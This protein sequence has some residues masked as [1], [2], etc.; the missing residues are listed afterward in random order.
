MSKYSTHTSQGTGQDADQVV[1]LRSTT[2][3]RWT[4][5]VLWAF[6]RAKLTA[7]PVTIA[8][9]GTGAASAAAARTAL[10]VDAAGDSRPPSG[11]AGG[12]LSGTYPNP[13]FAVDMATQGELNSEATTRADADTTLGTAL[14]A[15]IARAQDAEAA[16]QAYSIQ[17]ENHT[18]TQLA[19]TISDFFS[20]VRSTVLTGLSLAYADAIDATDTVLS[21]LGK[22]QGQV[23]LKAPINDTDLTGSTTIET[24]F[25]DG[26]NVETALAGK[27]ALNGDSDES[28]STNDL[29]A[30]GHVAAEGGFS[31]SGAGISNLNA[32]AL[33]SGTVPVARLPAAT[34]SAAGAVELATSA[35]A[36][37]GLDTVRA[38]TPAALA[39]KVDPLVNA[40]QPR[41][42]LVFDGTNYS[43]LS[44]PPFGTQDFSFFLWVTI[45]DAGVDQGFVG[46]DSNAFGL[47][48]IAGPKFLATKVN[49]ADASAACAQSLQLGRRYLVGYTRTGTAGTYWLDGVAAGTCVDSNDYSAPTKYLGGLTGG[50]FMRG[51]LSCPLFYNYAL[52]DAQVADLFMAGAPAAVDR[53]GSMTNIYSGQNADFN[54]G[55]GDWTTYGASTPSAVGNKMRVTINSGISGAAIYQLVPG[56]ALGRK[57]LATFT[58]SNFN[59]TS[60]NAGFTIEGN[61]GV[62][63]TGNGVKSGV[64]EVTSISSGGI[65]VFIGGSGTGETFDVDD[66]SLI[67]LGTLAQYDAHQI[68]A[69][70]QWRDVN[71]TTPPAHINLPGDGVT[72]GVAWALSASQ[73]T[74]FGETRTASGYALGRDAVVIPE[75]YRIESIWWSGDGTASFGN[76]AS[77]TEVINAG[78]A[79][80]T[81]LPATIAAYE[82][83]SRKLYITLG[84]ATTITYTVR[85]VR[86]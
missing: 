82:T 83:A 42:A 29:D 59:L 65:P 34:T 33:S 70:P 16:V 24:L 44:G 52:T 56:L 64:I 7:T 25:L 31:G 51:A 21:A 77:G 80:A 81:T 61:I 26:V 13:G 38:V 6:F 53:G 17:R 47:R 84:T 68:G 85:L 12:V 5:A 18:G 15:E 48:F 36:I 32:D 4:L 69:G 3:S 78:T 50:V 54:G 30:G 27:A 37:T 58:V 75:G 40:R 63:I 14:A 46:G 57:Y 1:G 22:L 86:I 66:F 43:T 45:A 60:G 41:Q 62:A 28:F 39:A 74:S 11:G 72:G 55:I 79:T 76:A 49:T 2:N 19:A 8:E 23:N 35:E 67:P 10:G 73:P 20:S 71:G 9:G